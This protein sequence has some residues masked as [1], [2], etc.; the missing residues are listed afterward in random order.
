GW[1]LLPT[2]AARRLAS[3]GGLGLK[4]SFRVG[5]VRRIA[6]HVKSSVDGQQTL[7][8]LQVPVL[9]GQNAGQAR[10]RPEFERAGPLIAG[11]RDRPLVSGRCRGR[12]SATGEEVA[13]QAMDFRLSPALAGFGRY[14][15]RFLER[16]MGEVRLVVVGV[17]VGEERQANRAK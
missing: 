17:G 4:Q 1:T 3:P 16:V 8:R 9:I 13:V 2:L 5:E 12:W 15:K 6:P 10:C 14:P 7:M 11:D